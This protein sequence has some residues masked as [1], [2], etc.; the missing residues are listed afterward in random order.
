MSLPLVE[1]RAALPAGF[2]AG[3]AA[4]GIKASGRPDLVLIRTTDGPAAAA[5]VF[6]PNAFAAAPVKQSQANLAAT[7]GDP[8]GRHGW[9]E[10]VISTSG[11]ANAA[12]GPAGDADQAEIGRIVGAATGVAVERVL[13]LSTG[14]IGTRLPLDRVAEGVASNL[15]GAHHRR[16]RAGG[17]GRGAA[18]DRFGHEARDD[19]RRA[20]G[21]RRRDRAGDG[22]GDRQGRRDDP[23]A[24]GHDARGRPDR[25]S[26]R[27][28]ACW[29][30]SCGRPRSGPGTSSRSTATRAPMTRSSCSHRGRPATRS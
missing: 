30:D 1:R 9:A 28:R 8:R 17:R 20:A 21:H 14:I 4:I 10:V 18:D 23:P 11:S 19:E 24:D 2:A 29:P 15:A 3:G 26:G 6:T 13:H 25:R 16:C 27:A 7:S 12:T 5:A 22:L